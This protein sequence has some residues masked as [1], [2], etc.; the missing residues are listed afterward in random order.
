MYCT[1]T[2]NSSP[3]GFSVS[4]HVSGQKAQAVLN[5]QQKQVFGD[6]YGLVV[7]DVCVKPPSRTYLDLAKSC[8]HSVAGPNDDLTIY[9]WCSAVN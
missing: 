6:R 2:A 1:G 4:Q 7:A 8:R 5:D 3:H 9:H